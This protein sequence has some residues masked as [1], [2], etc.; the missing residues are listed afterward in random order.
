M[1]CRQPRSR[2]GEMAGA[3]REV[4]GPASLPC[5][6]AQVGWPYGLEARAWAVGLVGVGRPVGEVARLVGVHPGT[7]RRWVRQATGRWADP[8]GAATGGEQPT[9]PNP[10]GG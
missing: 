8:A 7:V 9:G 6:A 4:P 1:G 3:G 2:V 10:G 5:S